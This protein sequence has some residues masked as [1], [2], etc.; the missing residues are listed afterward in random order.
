M[1]KEP[2]VLGSLFEKTGEYIETNVD[3]FKLKAIS[4]SSDVISSLA[5][6]LV[7]LIVSLLF[8]AML[9]IAVSL[10]I[11]NAMGNYYYGFFIVAGFYLLLGIVFYLAR[12]SIF[13]NPI[14]DMLI[15]KMHN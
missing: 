3:L 4:K 2:N 14:A 9:S 10:W 5:T 12:N 1:E 11:G 15:K 7:L 13:K 8:I 6:A